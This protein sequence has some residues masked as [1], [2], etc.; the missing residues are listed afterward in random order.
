MSWLLNS[1]IIFNKIT[2]FYFLGNSSLVLFDSNYENALCHFSP[3]YHKFLFICLFWFEPKASGTLSTGI[4]LGLM[5]T[6][7]HYSW[8]CFS[9]SFLMIPSPFPRVAHLWISIYGFVPVA[10]FLNR[11]SCLFSLDKHRLSQNLVCYTILMIP[12]PAW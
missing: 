6:P 10:L 2:I 8:L 7:N 1:E 5:I 3:N 12:K 11:S 9:T 4:K